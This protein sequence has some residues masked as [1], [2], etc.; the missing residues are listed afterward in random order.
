MVLVKMD[1]VYNCD[2]DLF[3]GLTYFIPILNIFEAVNV[4][5][6]IR[7]Q[8]GIDGTSINDCLTIFF[9]PL[10]ALAQETME[11]KNIPGL[12]SMARE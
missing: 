3:S 4:R 12:M 8:N 9:C 1:A 5:G 7:E 10:C 2:L 11:V 6:K